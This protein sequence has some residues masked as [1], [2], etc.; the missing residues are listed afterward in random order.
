M[1]VIA[2]GAIPAFAQK[3]PHDFLKTIGGFSDGDLAKLDAGD[4]ITTTL[5]THVKNELALMGAA[6][7]EGT[8]QTFLEV[9]RDI[10]TFEKA[11]GTA[12]MLSEPPKMADLQG[13]DFDK[14]ELKSLEHCKLEDCGIKLDQQTLKELQ[15]QIDWS[16]Q[17]SHEA[18]ARFLRER[19]FD[20][21]K[22]YQEGGNASLAVYRNKSKPRFVA[23]EFA[24]LL[25]KSPYLLQ[26]R[27]KLNAYLLDYPK[28]TLAGASDF[29]YW[30]VINFGPKPTMRLIHVTIDPPEEGTNVATIISSKQLYYSHYFDT[31]LELY[32]L[33]PDSE[34]P[35]KVFYVVALNRY[36]TDLGGGLSGKVMRLGATSGTKGAMKNTIAAAQAAVQERSR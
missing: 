11:I 25:E 30:D 21:A 31:G 16:A 18:V 5:D 1:V 35:D 28:G 33:I 9:Y 36:R 17:N 23:K 15:S 14:G 13:L 24:A 3:Q 19:I 2:M 6:R 10:E 26:Y 20:Y 22:A 29:L 4:V 27:P 32:S 8:I 12:K 7:I 34:Q